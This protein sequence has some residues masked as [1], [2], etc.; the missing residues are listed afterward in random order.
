MT[1]LQEKTINR[2]KNLRPC[3]YNSKQDRLDWEME[4]HGILVN[5]FGDK[6]IS[7]GVKIKPYINFHANKRAY[8]HTK[9]LCDL[10]EPKRKHLAWILN[11]HSDIKSPD[12]VAFICRGESHWQT[13]T[14]KEVFCHAGISEDDAKGWS[15]KVIAFR[16]GGKTPK[17]ETLVR[18]LSEGKRSHLAFRLDRDTWCGLIT[19]CYVGRCDGPWGQRSLYEVFRMFGKSDHASKCLATR[20]VNFGDVT[21]AKKLREL[22]AEE[23]RGGRNV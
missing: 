7:E 18:E 21:A 3:G 22:M 4:G 5:V 9:R 23:R 17:Y 1:E 8:A 14:L 15:R 20:V 2:I 16:P 19:A 11:K 10:S 13:A 12:A 6:S